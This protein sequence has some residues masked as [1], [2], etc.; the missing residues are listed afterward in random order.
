[1]LKDNLSSIYPFSFPDLFQTNYAPP[2]V[3]GLK[4]QKFEIVERF[5]LPFRRQIFVQFKESRAPLG[6][7][8]SLGRFCRPTGDR[9]HSCGLG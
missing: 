9:I 6:G 7:S 4:S 1:M 5:C 2:F 8:A 3:A